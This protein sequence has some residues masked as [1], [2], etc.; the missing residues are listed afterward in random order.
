MISPK[1]NE[2]E[3]SIEYVYELVKK[4]AY[5]P[6][7][8]YDL[9]KIKVGNEEFE[10]VK[11][12]TT[13]DGARI[14]FNNG[15]YN[16]FKLSNMLANQIKGNKTPSTAD[17]LVQMCAV[18]YTQNNDNSDEEIDR[19]IELFWK[20]DSA[21]AW[22]CYFFFAQLQNKW[23]DFFLSYTGKT[24]PHKEQKAKQMTAKEKL[25][26]TYGKTIIGKLLRSRS[27]NYTPLIM[28]W[29]V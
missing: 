4:F 22:S 7:E 26:N 16:Q 27:A 17:C 10:L 24:T 14:Y 11:D 15:N 21:T 18:L 19:K 3:L 9:P 5:T 29:K 12:T 25:R 20:L 8:Y 2:G 6:L 13:I 1:G 28:D 23:K